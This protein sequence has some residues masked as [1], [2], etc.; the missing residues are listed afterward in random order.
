MIWQDILLMIGGFGF[1]VALFPAV[2]AREKPPRSTCLLT[3]T[4]LASFTIAYATLGL[5]LAFVATLVTSTMWFILL[6]QK[7]C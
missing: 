2:R 7:R 4:I 3:G 5:W 6:C 1:S